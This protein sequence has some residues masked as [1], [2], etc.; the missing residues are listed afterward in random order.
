MA[1]NIRIAP[2][3][4]KRLNDTTAY[5]AEELGLPQSAAA[6]HDELETKL[7]IIAEFP[8]AYM[9]DEEASKAIG[10]EVRGANIRSFKLMYWIDDDEKAVLAFAL[11]FRG[12]DP[13]LLK[14]YR[15]L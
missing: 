15:F 5:I 1:Y 8:R 11:R 14:R 7:K 9:V 13:K 6:L 3:F 4:A 10:E 12:E 2:A